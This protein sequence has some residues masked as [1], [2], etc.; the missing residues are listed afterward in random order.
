MVNSKRASLPFRMCDQQPYDGSKSEYDEYVNPHFTFREL[1]IAYL[2][3]V[4]SITQ[5]L[6]RPA[7]RG[8]RTEDGSNN[9]SINEHSN[10]LNQSGSTS[11][12]NGC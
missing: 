11:A 2:S 12:E 3:E 5:P 9:M 8:N 7:Y 10:S 4:K 1:K 6:N